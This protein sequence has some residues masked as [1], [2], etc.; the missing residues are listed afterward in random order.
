M[1]SDDDDIGIKLQSD[2][3]SDGTIMRKGSNFW[4]YCVSQQHQ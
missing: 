2:S 3:Y 4:Y 1:K